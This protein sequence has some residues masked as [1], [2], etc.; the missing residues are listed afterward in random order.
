MKT[1]NVSIAGASGYTGQ[2]L[3]RLLLG[4]PL[5]RIHNLYGASSAGET[6]ATV[7]PAFSGIV[8]QRIESMDGIKSDDA[9][10]LFLCLPHGESAAVVASLKKAGNKIAI[11]D[12]G[13]DFRFRNASDYTKFYKKDHPAPEL[14]GSFEYGLPE[15]NRSEIQ[16]ARYVANPGC[17][18]TAIQL[19][20]LPLVQSGFAGD[21]HITGV[22]G[23]SGSGNKPSATTH[24]S[25]RHGNLKPYKVLE[26]QHMGE[27][28]QSVRQITRVDPLI[29]FTPVSGP[30]VRGIWVNISIRNNHGLDPEE[31]FASAYY[32]APFVRLGEGMPELKDVV[33]SNFADIGWASDGHSL[34]VSVVIDNLVKGASGQAI[35][36]MNLMF[37]LPETTGLMNPGFLL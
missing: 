32:N 37:D 33:G 24:F 7:N 31:V 11:V 36:N 18:A 13:S 22:T 12:L 16:G 10:V 35:H 8:E 21:F 34:A 27:V 29:A 25:T 1:L 26:H 19:G 30:F 14:L 6:Y 4:H 3:V 9:D 15:F 20:I 28:Y 23:S 2:E 17:F 5:A